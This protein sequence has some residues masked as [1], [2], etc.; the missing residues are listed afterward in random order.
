MD[1]QIEC[2]CILR[3]KKFVNKLFVILIYSQVGTRAASSFKA[4]S[5]GGGY[6]LDH[7]IVF[8]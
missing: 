1:I 3:Y 2:V 5:A 7:V 4:R 6:A 8:F